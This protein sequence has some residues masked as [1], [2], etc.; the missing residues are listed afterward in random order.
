MKLKV[1]R[2]DVWAVSLVD[3]P[4][5][6]AAKLEPLVQAGVNMQFMIA[7]RAPEKKGRGVV[8]LT[9]VKGPRQLRAARKAGFRKASGLHSVR[10]E[11]ADRRGICLKMAKVLKAQG[12]NLRGFSAA[13]IGK[14]FIAHLGLESNAAANKA[15]KLLRKL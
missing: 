1:T 4:G 11:G 15:V 5:G 8:F 14:R 3:K 9:P 6:L 13:A 12:I 10:V 7:R 2:T